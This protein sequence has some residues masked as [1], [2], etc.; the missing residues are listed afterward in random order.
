[1]PEMYATTLSI[2][3][4]RGALAQHTAN[5]PDDFALG[6]VPSRFHEFSPDDL[7]RDPEVRDLML[8]GDSSMDPTVRKEAYAKALALI[9]DRAYAV[10]LYT[11]P[12]YYV[13]AKGLSFRPPADAIPKFYEMS[14]K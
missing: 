9:A 12:S 6:G 1:M 3:R 2:R 14:W 8:K 11:K 13:A 4:R 5:P 10:P 7:N